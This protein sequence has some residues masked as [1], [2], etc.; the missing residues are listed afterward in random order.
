MNAPPCP[1]HGTAMNCLSTH[2]P[3]TYYCA[4]CNRRYNPQLT[5][6]PPRERDTST[7]QTEEP[8]PHDD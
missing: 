4:E 1:L 5:V 2:N 7:S 6:A 8:T 3:W